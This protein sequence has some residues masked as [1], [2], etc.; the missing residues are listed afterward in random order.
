VSIPGDTSLD[1]LEIT[2]AQVAA[3][4]RVLAGTAKRIDAEDDLPRV[5]AALK[6]Q[7]DE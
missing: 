1:G 2:P 6:G 3:A 4:C 5:L 7:E